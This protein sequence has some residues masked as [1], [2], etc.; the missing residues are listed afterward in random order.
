MNTLKFIKDF[1]GFVLIRAGSR[2]CG[3][4]LSLEAVATIHGMPKSNHYVRAADKLTG[5][6]VVVDDRAL[7]DITE[8][9]AWVLAWLYIADEEMIT[10]W[11]EE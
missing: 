9:G 8:D 7:V 6:D 3:Q 4:S 11:V 10:V 5:L 2:L 1:I